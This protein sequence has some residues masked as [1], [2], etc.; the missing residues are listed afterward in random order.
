M[1]KIYI[2][3]LATIGIIIIS[4]N[5]KDEI[6]IAKPFTIDEVYNNPNFY[7]YETE[8]DAYNYNIEILDSIKTLFN[9]N[10]FKLI[11]YTSPSCECGS[12]YALFPQT[13]KVLENASLSNYEI[14]L[15]FNVDKKKL[16]VE[17]PYSHL[18]QI[19]TSP[20]IYLLKSEKYY[21]DLLLHIDTEKISIER[22]LLDGIK[23]LDTY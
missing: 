3:I 19:K 8:Y 12:L 7:W 5:S 20:S 4:C 6:Q 16:K 18:F 13:I 14:Y 10:I 17:H 21:Y 2:L 23:F 9:E 11:I 15:I 22:A 1:K